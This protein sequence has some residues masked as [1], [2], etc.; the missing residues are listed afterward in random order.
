MNVGQVTW[1]SLWKVSRRRFCVHISFK[2]QYYP[3]LLES[4]AVFVEAASVRHAYVVVFVS[5]RCNATTPARPLFKYVR[6][7]ARCQASRPKWVAQTTDT[8]CDLFSTCS[9]DEGGAPL[10]YDVRIVTTKTQSRNLIFEHSGI[11]ML[12][13]SGKICDVHSGLDLLI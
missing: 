11:E 7:C 1:R 4:G 2:Q 12:H 10:T 8:I 5:Y 9:T 6:Y 3:L 13:S